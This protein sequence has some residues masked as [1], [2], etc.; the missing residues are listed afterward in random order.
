M[1]V[2]YQAYAEYK[3]SGV[4]WLGEVPVQWNLCRLKFMANIRNGRDYKAV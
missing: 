1:S 3:G 2:E 4:E